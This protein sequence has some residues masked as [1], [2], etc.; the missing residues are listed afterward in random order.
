MR[1]GDSPGLSDDEHLQVVHVPLTQ[2]DR[3][4]LE[5]DAWTRFYYYLSTA[6]TLLYPKA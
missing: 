6:Y 5:I 2:M 1:K 3:T 4:A